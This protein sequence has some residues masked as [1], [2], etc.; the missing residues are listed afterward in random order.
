MLTVI[1]MISG[2]AGAIFSSPFFMKPRFESTAIVYPI[3]IISLSDESETEQMLELFEMD[4]IKDTV[5][6]RFE[7]YTRHDL[8]PGKPEYQYYVD[9]LYQERVSISPTKN[10][11]VRIACQDEDPE[12]AKQMVE[13]IIDEF[14]IGQRELTI[15]QHQDYMTLKEQELKYLRDT[16]DSLSLRLTKL[17]LDKRVVFVEGEAERYAEGLAELLE[18]NASQ[19]RIDQLEERIDNLGEVGSE[20]SFL[21]NSINRLGALHAELA[22]EMTREASKINNPLDYAKVVRKPRAADKKK[23]PVRWLIV[24][25]SL[26]AGAFAGIVF[27]VAAERISAS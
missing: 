5:I 22:R 11:S 25:I 4:R 18:S 16:K 8:V 21:R 27:V 15:D 1:I 3:N 26:I 17:M 19:A 24:L 10:E 20:V 2:I 23:Y 9:L 14:N 12:V 13:T 6:N 7:L